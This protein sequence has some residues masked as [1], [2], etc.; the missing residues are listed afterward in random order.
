MIKYI[1][2]RPLW[3]SLIHGEDADD[4]SNLNERIIVLMKQHGGSHMK[5]LIA[6]INNFLREISMHPDQTDL[7]YSMEACVLEMKKGLE[8]TNS[9]IKMIPTYI[10]SNGTPP[11][12]V[13]AITVDAGGTNLRIALVTFSEGRPVISNMNVYPIPGS[14]GQISAD[15][16]FNEIADKILPLTEV[17]NKI[18][19][20]FSYPAEIFPNRDGKNTPAV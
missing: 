18:G 16:F 14:L 12:G 4:S 5:E 2:K 17:S 11:N 1:C 7:Q 20:C 10:S 9:S 19:F 13:P 6:R 15:A 3:I 8:G